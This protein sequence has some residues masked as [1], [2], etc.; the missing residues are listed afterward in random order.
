MRIFQQNKI[1]QIKDIK[2]KKALA[3]Q[4]LFLYNR[5]TKLQTNRFNMKNFLEMK[6]SDIITTMIGSFL[7]KKE[8][9]DISDIINKTL[10]EI[11]PDNVEI[12]EITPQI[13]VSAY[14]HNKYFLRTIQ[15][16]IEDK[17]FDYFIEDME[18]YIDMVFIDKE[19]LDLRFS[20]AQYEQVNIM[21]LKRRNKKYS[22][23]DVER[24]V[25]SASDLFI[26]SFDQG[27]DD[28]YSRDF[29]FERVEDLK[30]K[31]L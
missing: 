24:I 26:N 2:H 31:K 5:T 22:Y 18:D 8:V 14:A 16:L 12:K 3:F 19:T 20:E 27:I 10:N 9:E 13:I 15:F 21:T 25:C 30:I 29:F 17:S 7:E 4:A 28:T 23:K 1:Y 6:T 11:K